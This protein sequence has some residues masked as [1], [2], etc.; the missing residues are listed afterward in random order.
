MKEK[1]KN[2]SIERRKYPRIEKA[3]S[4]ILKGDIFTLTTETKNLSCS[5]VYCQVSRPVP[6]LSKLAVTL[7][8]PEMGQKAVG[9]HEIHCRGAVVRSERILRENGSPAK[10]FIAIYFTKLNPRDRGK[11][12]EYVSHQLM[13]QT[14]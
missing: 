2:K 7:L 13:H 4:I 1:N 10:Y 9:L 8:V 12:G 5:G 14:L 11:I 6:E 3:L